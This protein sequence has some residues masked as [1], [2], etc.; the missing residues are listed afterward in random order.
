[1]EALAAYENKRYDVILMDIQMP[2]MDGIEA[3][4]RIREKEGE[5]RHTP[6]VALTGFALQWD[7][8]RF[9]AMGMDE[10]ISKPV[11]MEDLF[12]V[13]EQVCKMNGQPNPKFSE[14][15]R[16]NDQGELVF[17]NKAEAKTEEEL[18][19][20]I[21]G[22]NKNIKELIAVLASN[23]LAAIEVIAHRIKELFNQIDGV[24]VLKA[25]RDLE[26]QKGILPEKRAKIIMTTA[27]GEAELV[28]TAF[29]YGCEAYASKPI[30]IEKLVE[31]MKKLGLI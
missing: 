28:K 24:K 29:E 23:D 16:L 1:M 17:L 18:Q 19:P 13:I 25:I 6:I 20:V 30:D 7:R 31:V 4:K 11:K 12:F 9:L 14:M 27:L 22:I 10:Y 2:E 5:N 21:E 3:T 26:T 8:E 15:P